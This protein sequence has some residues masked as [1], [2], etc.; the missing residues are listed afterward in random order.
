MELLII[1][2]L[3][4]VGLLKGIQCGAGGLYLKHCLDLYLEPCISWLIILVGHH[5]KSY[6]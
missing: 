6:N 1:L 5:N 3:D 4:V 2:L